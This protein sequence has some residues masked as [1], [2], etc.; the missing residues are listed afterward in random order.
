[1]AVLK[2]VGASRYMNKRMSH[3]VIE[4][5]GLTPDIQ[6]ESLV[7]S[8][9]NATYTDALNNKHPI[10]ELVE[11]AQ[12]DQPAETKA[13]DPVEDKPASVKKKA[14]RKKATRTRKSVED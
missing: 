2:L 7:K 8:L 9:L 12:V 6:D 5:G 4:K 3:Q 1:M 10:F 11:T 14:T 13:E